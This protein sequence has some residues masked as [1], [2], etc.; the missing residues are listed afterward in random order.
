MQ[1]PIQLE[2]E[3]N[4]KGATGRRAASR[5]ILSIPRYA[6]AGEEVAA[7]EEAAATAV[8]AGE[9]AQH[10]T[11][12]RLLAEPFRFFSPDQRLAVVHS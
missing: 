1:E 4:R 11:V 3:R 2:Q 12:G 5:A 8:A 7:G 6:A 10:K 9:E